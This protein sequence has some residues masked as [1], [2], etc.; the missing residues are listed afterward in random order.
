MKPITYKF[1]MDY[2]G[3]L[4]GIELWQD[5]QHITL[6]MSP[7]DTMKNG[8]RWQEVKEFMDTVELPRQFDRNNMM[9][10]IVKTLG[11]EK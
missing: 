9:E 4:S 11:G 2:K 7:V 3:T 8:Y 10:T 1:V 6:D 5:N